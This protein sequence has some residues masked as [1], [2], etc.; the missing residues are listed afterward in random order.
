[1]GPDI[2]KVRK[3]TRVCVKILKEGTTVDMASN[4]VDLMRQMLRLGSHNNVVKLLGSNLATRP[5]FIV[6]EFVEVHARPLTDDF[7]RSCCA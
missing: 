2:R 1:M 7:R 3:G 5:Y 6:M 4:E